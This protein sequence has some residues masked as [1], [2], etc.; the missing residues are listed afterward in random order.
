M[1]VCIYIFHLVLYDFHVWVYILFISFCGDHDMLYGIPIEI[2]NYLAI[3]INIH[4]I[5]LIHIHI[6]LIEFDIC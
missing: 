2:T 6:C 5:Y 4:K 3:F 1:H